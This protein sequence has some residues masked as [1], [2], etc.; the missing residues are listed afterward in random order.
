M[1]LNL[2]FSVLYIV[3]I[4]EKIMTLNCFSEKRLMKIK[5]FSKGFLCNSSIVEL[6]KNLF[7]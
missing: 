6:T 1:L 2:C 3:K 7:F 4:T 5:N